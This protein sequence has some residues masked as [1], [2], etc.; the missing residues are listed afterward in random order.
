MDFKWPRLKKS[1]N[2]SLEST[3]IQIKGKTSSLD[4]KNKKKNEGKAKIHKETSEY[5]KKKSK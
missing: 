5:E 4:D 3:T 2:K 1:Q